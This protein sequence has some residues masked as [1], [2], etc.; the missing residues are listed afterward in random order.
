MLISK[1]EIFPTV[2][3]KFQFNEDE[4]SPLLKEMVDK[5]ERL[6]KQEVQK[7]CIKIGTKVMQ[8]EKVRHWT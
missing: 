3:R 2:I 8:T 5:K 7:K 6:K 1:Q 4:M